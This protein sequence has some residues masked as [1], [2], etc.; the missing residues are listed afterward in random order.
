MAGC[1]G[2]LTG[3][4]TNSPASEEWVFPEKVRVELLYNSKPYQDFTFSVAKPGNATVSIPSGDTRVIY[5]LVAQP[6]KSGGIRGDPRLEDFEGEMQADTASGFAGN[7]VHPHASTNA[8]NPNWDINGFDSTEQQDLTYDRLFL[9]AD[10]GIPN[11]FNNKD[12]GFGKTLKG[13]GW[14]G[15]VPVFRPSGSGTK[16]AWSTPRFWGNGRATTNTPPDWLLLDVFHMGMFQPDVNGTFVSR[17]RVN[18][19]GAKSFFQTIRGSTERADSI[20]DSVVIGAGTKDFRTSV[21]GDTGWKTIDGRQTFRTNVLRQI[22]SLIEPRNT[23]NEPY[24]THFHFLADLAATNISGSTAPS[25]SWMAPNTNTGS[26]YTAT[27][28][29]DRRIE[30]IVRSL[31]QKLTT[32]GNQFSIFSLA[33][34]LQPSP[35]GSVAIPGTSIKANI[36]GEAYLQAVYERAPEYNEATGA[37]TNGSATGAPP[38]RQLYLRELRY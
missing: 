27:N 8:L 28:T 26:I 16:L 25:G 34:A 29:T 3:A 4:S 6:R 11:Y 15:E 35:T 24:A 37:I 13:I 12:C 20:I 23:S 31:N 1:F 30:G 21:Y 22:N 36:V 5:A 14:L 18:V 38:M 17:G 33:Q 9:E 7:Y 10:S 32:H 2:V 19:N